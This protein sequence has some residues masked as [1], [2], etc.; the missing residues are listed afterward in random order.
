ML[1]E[2]FYRKFNEKGFL[3]SKEQIYNLFI[4]LQ[5]KPFVILSGISG[6]G[7]SKII[8]IFAEILSDSKEQLALVPVKPNWRD[9][10]N[11]FG[12]HNLVNDT[13]STTPILKLILRAQANPEKPFFLILDEMN[14]AKVEQYFAD[15]LSLLETRRYIKS[16][17]VTISDLKSIFSFPIGTKLS[18]AIVMACLH[19]NPNNKMQDVSNYRENIFSK[20]WREQ[21]SSSSDDSWKPQFRTELNQKD[22]SGH[23]SRLA[24]KLFDGGNGSYQ[25]K[26]YATLDK[27]LQDEFDSIK[28][29]YDIMKS[30]SLDITQHSINLHSATVLKSN[31]SQPDYKQGEK[32]VQ[33]I[34]PN[35]SY[36]VPQEV[37]IPLNLF[38]VGTV[39]V[40]ET[41]HMFSPK[42]LDRSNV[43]EMNEVNLESILK[44][45]KYANNDNL[46]DDTYFFNID[47]PP[48]IINLSNTAHIVEMESRFSDQFEDVFKI[49]ESLKNYN[50]HFG[51]RVFNEISN[52]C[53]NA[54][55]SGNAPISV[56]T[57]I[58]IL[59]KILPKL[60]GSTEQLFNPLMSILSLCLLN[61][62]NNLSAKLDFNEGEYQTILSELKSKSSKNNGQ[63]VSMFKYPRS[64]KKVIS[65]IKNLMYNG[66]TSFIE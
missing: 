14:L 50:K 56:A 58:Q 57:D 21:F 30:Q 8:E 37:E 42:V 34:A 13:Y 31:D 23:P 66:F 55:K 27:S 51:Y 12:Y 54:V 3:Y 64:G 41:T 49:N 28:K 52:Y 33:G 25:L 59:Q 43:I 61:D 46:K 7:K 65:M 1:S 26:D 44:K 35:E 32:L 40:D 48:L 36:Y 38:V 17:L 2:D 39:N 53:L 45:S 29:V 15:F 47:V 63:L 18:E 5:T 11:V 4:S 16:S 6:S 62:T 24:G 60:H 20:L 10:R 22:S 19:M 9:N